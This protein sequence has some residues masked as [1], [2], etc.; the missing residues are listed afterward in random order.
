MGPRRSSAR[1]GQVMTSPRPSS[2]L[3]S[4]YKSRHAARVH[5]VGVGGIG[6]SGIAEGL[7]NLGYTVSGSDLKES[8]VTRRLVS[9]RP[10]IAHRHPSE[11]PVD[12]DVGGISP[13]GQ[14]GKP[15]DRAAPGPKT[16]RLA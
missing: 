12:P 3:S 16:P 2:P 15:Q 13:A 1:G 14:K 11:N 7:I 10:R 8:E 5:F 4:R 6:M 9:L